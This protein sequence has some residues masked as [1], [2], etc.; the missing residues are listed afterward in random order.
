MS[1]VRP[2][3]LSAVGSF[4]LAVVAWIVG[5]ESG[6]LWSLRPAYEYCGG[7]VRALS[8]HF[9]P[10]THQCSYTDGTSREL[11]PVWVNPLFFASLAATL[12]LILLAM[13]AANRP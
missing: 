6:E 10:L 11:V 9:I 12:V 7:H 8:W 2:L 1:S 13:R 5:V 3:L 4:L